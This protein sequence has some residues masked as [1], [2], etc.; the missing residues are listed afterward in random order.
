VHDAA[1]KERGTEDR[2]RQ[3][4]I[5]SHC[6]HNRFPA[7]S[8]EADVATARRYRRESVRLRR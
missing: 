3:E 6:S 2:D 5:S 8:A 4:S 1:T 7:H